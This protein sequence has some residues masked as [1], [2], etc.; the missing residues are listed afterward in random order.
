[1]DQV[2]IYTTPAC[3]WCHKVKDYLQNKGVTYREVDV[4]KDQ[5]AATNLVS[6]TGQRSVP[7]T[8]KGSSFVI[9]YDPGQLDKILM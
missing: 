3:P 9:G 5:E 1:M 4:A 6:L 8:A 2:T 7:V